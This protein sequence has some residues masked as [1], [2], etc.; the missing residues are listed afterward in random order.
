MQSWLVQ[1]ARDKGSSPMASN[2]KEWSESPALEVHEQKHHIVFIFHYEK[3]LISQSGIAPILV[4]AFKIGF[5]LLNYI[6]ETQLLKKNP[7]RTGAGYK[8]YSAQ[9]T[10]ES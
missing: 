9:R 4:I 6:T 5:L 3:R 7:A 8:G 1:A 10:K 2:G